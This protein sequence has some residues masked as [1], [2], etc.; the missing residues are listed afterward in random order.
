MIMALN[1]PLEY[2]A[3]CTYTSDAADDLTFTEGEDLLVYW[4]N[5]SGWWYGA[6]TDGARGWFPGSYVEV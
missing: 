3:I 1:S 2:K 6:R 4:G 5:D